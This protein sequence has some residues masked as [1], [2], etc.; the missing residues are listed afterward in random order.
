[1]CVCLSG[2]P[3]LMVN[4][5]L[6]D[7]AAGQFYDLEKLFR[8]GGAVPDTSYIFMV[9]TCKPKPGGAFISHHAACPS[10]GDFV[11]PGHYSLE[12]LTRLLTLKVKCVRWA[13]NRADGGPGVVRSVIDAVATGTLTA[14]CCSVETTR[15]GK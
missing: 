4:L 5:L 10:Q 8:T 1:M 2:H 15:H 3:V 9:P 11:D 12:T 7:L 6:L 13:G 14:W